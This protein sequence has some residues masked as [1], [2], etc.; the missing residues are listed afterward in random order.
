MR[1]PNLEK[2]PIPYRP[3]H[4]ISPIEAEMENLFEHSMEPF[5]WRP[6]W[7]SRFVPSGMDLPEP[8]VDVFEEGGDI[9][10]KVEVP[11]MKRDDLEVR[12]DDGRLV[13]RGEKRK[14]EKTERKDYFR[15]ERSYGAFSR[16]IE[17]P[18]EVRQ[19]K[20]KATF[21]DG[22]LEVRLPKTEEAKKKEVRVKIEG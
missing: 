1:R 13:I 12:L 20:V 21:K 11:G 3:G 2:A 22:V 16:S 7:M 8:A 5:R 18:C 6:G 17:L 15:R 4:W 10:V 19:E 9:V 14:E